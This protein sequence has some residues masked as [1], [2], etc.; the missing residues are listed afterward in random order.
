MRTLSIQSL[1][2][3]GLLMALGC[4]R[5]LRNGGYVL[6][7]A[8]EPREDS[9]GL[10]A[11]DGSLPGIWL[12]RTGDEVKL[13]FDLLGKESPVRMSGRFKAQLQGEAEEFSADGSVSDVAVDV[14]GLSC[15]VEFGQIHLDA[16]IPEGQDERFEG[17]LTIHEDLMPDQDPPCPQ[18]CKVSVA[19][20]A[21]KAP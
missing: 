19:F 3:A 4:G 1:G 14:E 17:T 21:V 16:T 13:D 18:T 12:M 9:C 6:T 15:I 20:L 10:L 11:E 7:Q 5:D 8:A 2:L